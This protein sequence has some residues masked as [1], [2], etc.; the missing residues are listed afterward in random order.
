MESGQSSLQGSSVL[1][2]GLWPRPRLMT[3]KGGWRSRYN[4]SGPLELGSEPDPSIHL[5]P[6]PPGSVPWRLPILAGSWFPVGGTGRRS[7]WRQA[8]S[9]DLICTPYPSPLCTPGSG[10]VP[11]SPLLSVGLSSWDPVFAPPTSRWSCCAWIPRTSTA[12][13]FPII[14][15]IPLQIISS[16]V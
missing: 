7:E 3:V 9:R 4:L 10:D 6:S 11:L 2:R 16:L 5:C 13:L 15:S 14:L 8:K 12:L 1:P